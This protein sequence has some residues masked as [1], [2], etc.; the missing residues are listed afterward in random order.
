[1]T[2][3]RWGY[4]RRSDAVAPEHTARHTTLFVWDGDALA[5]E[6][7]QDK[8]VTYL[9]EP[10]SFVPLAR[11]ESEGG[12]GGALGKVEEG[13][14]VSDVGP[15][16]AVHMWY[17]DQWALPSARQGPARQAA[18]QADVRAEEDHQIAWR[19]RLL[20]ADSAAPRDRIDYYNCDHLGTPR[21]LVDGQGRVVWSARYKAWGRMIARDAWI[22]RESSVNEV[23]QQLRFQ[24]QYED[25]ETGLHYNRYRFYDPDSARFMV[26]DPMGLLGGLNGYAYAPN[27]TIWVDPLGLAKC[28]PRPRTAA[29]EM[30]NLPQ[31]CNERPCDIRKVL[32]GRGYSMVGANKNPSGLN[33]SGQVWTKSMSDGNTAAVRLDP[34]TSRLPPLGRADEV[35][36]AHKEIVPTSNVINGNY[37]PPKI[38]GTIECD[39]LGEVAASGDYF[40]KHIPIKKGRLR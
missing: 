2:E 14:T 24:G 33:S 4:D 26:Q 31:F 3:E 9:Y 25:S 12:H 21:E 27:P 28:G 39:D 23:G 30:K 20:G 11:I 5:Q 8:T 19:Q 7:G 34:A 16:R 35:P 38:A 37:G 36:H 29:A 1:V 40:A 10:D 15:G 32:S 13:G 22:D 18:T 17:V 6:V